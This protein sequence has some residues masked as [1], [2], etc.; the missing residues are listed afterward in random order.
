LGRKITVIEILIDG[1]YLE[2]L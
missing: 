1:D 2:M